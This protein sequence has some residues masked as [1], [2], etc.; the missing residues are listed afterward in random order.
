MARIQLQ[1][2]F[3]AV[4]I[5]TAHALEASGGNAQKPVTGAHSISSSPFNE[6]FGEFVRESLDIWHVPGMS[7][8][9][10]D[11]DDVYTEAS[12]RSPRQPMQ[13]L[14]TDLS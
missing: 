11:G 4:A 10:I 7:V 13:I 12:S 1:H 3:I 5:A 9:V 6:D 8:G 14:A 2:V